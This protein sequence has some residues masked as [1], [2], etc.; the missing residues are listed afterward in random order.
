MLIT[1]W[2]QEG[3]HDSSHHVCIPG[4][5]EMAPITVLI[6]GLLLGRTILDSY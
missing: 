4:K 1:A 3:C 2:S 5:K 6:V